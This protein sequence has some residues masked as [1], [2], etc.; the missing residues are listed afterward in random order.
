MSTPIDICNL[1]L[2]HI[3]KPAINSFEEASSEARECRR[4]YDGVRRSLLQYSDWTFARRREAMALLT[5][6][7][8]QRWTFKYARPTGVLKMLRVLP[9]N[10][11][12]RQNPRPNPFEVREGAVFTDVG[13]AVAE[14]TRDLTETARYSPLFID[15]VSYKLAQRIARPLTKS[16]KLTAEMKEEAREHLSLAVEADAAQDVGRY[17]YD[18]DTVIDRE[19][20][21]HTFWGQ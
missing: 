9:P 20:R 2:G 15:A 3:G 17:N 14:F 19:L 7:Y 12:L 11:D 21:P 10:A 16:T 8:Q 6:D 5:N 18:A 4:Y 13:E 1:A